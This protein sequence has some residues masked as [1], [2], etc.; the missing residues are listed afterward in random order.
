M[1]QVKKGN[2]WHFST[3]T[4][5]RLTARAGALQLVQ[6][7]PLGF[8]TY[9]RPVQLSYATTGGWPSYV[10]IRARRAGFFSDVISVAIRALRS[11]PRDPEAI[12]PAL[13]RFPVFF[14]AI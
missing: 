1:H 3:A 6:L 12:Y 10:H 8:P 14:Y 5:G 2:A 11:I 4:G 7:H 13:V 9:R